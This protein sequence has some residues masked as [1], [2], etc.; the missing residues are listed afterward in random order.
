MMVPDGTCNWSGAF[1]LGFRPCGTMVPMVPDGEFSTL[2][3]V[4]VMVKS[5]FSACQH[6]SRC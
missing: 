2:K 3:A 1:F 6:A 4:S 5:T